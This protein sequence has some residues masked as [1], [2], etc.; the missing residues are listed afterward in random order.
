MPI[1]RLTGLL[2]L[3]LLL[4]ACA[5]LGVGEPSVQRA[6][7]GPSPEEIHNARFVR[8]YARLPNFEESEIF[9]QQFEQ[10]V[11]AYF[12]RHP[13]LA[14]SERAVNFRP[15]GRVVVGMSKAEVTLLA[16]E[17]DARTVEPAAMQKAAR[18]F[19]PAIQPRAQEMWVYPG[20]WT[21][22][23]D[24]ERLTDIV[25]AGKEPL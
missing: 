25:V 7:E 13:E 19:W 15:R 5:V 16:G 24:A 1:P 9:R 23:F 11:T 17:P 6:V 10:R 22:Y 20:G 4:P 12:A 21:F 14:T 2:L 8:G 3:A 18:H